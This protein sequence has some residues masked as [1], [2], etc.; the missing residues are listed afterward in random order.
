MY[1]APP[2]GNWMSTLSYPDS[3]ARLDT[4]SLNAAGFFGELSPEQLHRAARR[5]S[6]IWVVEGRTSYGN[7]VRIR[8]DPRFRRIGYWSFRTRQLSLYERV[9]R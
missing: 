2:A 6:R 9:P 1:H 4:Q 3:I 8:D 7:G 5:L